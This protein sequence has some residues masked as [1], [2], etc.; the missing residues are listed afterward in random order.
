MIYDGLEKIETDE[1]IEGF[2]VGDKAL[3]FS[4]KF[5][6][7]KPFAVVEGENDILSVFENGC[8]NVC[9]LGGNV[10][11]ETFEILSKAEDTIYTLL[12]N[13][14]KGKEYEDKLND[15]FP[16]KDL[17][18]V[19]YSKDYKDPDEYFRNNPEPLQ[20]KDLIKDAKVL[21]TE[22]FKCN[23]KEFTE[24]KCE[25]RF[26]SLIFNI[27]KVDKG[28]IAGQVNLYIGGKLIDR[29]DNV[30]L[31]EILN[32]LEDANFKVVYDR[33]SSAYKA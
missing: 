23:H 18:H 1:V 10:K 25:N 27:K 6:F 24:W 20:F 17:R 22:I 14:K 5:S 32:S 16:E 21:N 19:K 3:L 26:K 15:L 12:D 9:G 33:L 7:K 30:A 28:I 13:D 2:S 29:E 4:P 11:E 8:E 31:I